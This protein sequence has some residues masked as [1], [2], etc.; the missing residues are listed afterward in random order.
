MRQASNFVESVFDAGFG[1]VIERALVHTASDIIEHQEE[2][3]VETR[4]AGI[5]NLYRKSLML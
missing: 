3:E 5:H 2:T 1:K 4:G